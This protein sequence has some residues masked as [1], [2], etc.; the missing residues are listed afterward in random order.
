VNEI[1]IYQRHNLQKRNPF[2]LAIFDDSSNDG[3]LVK[4][5]LENGADFMKGLSVEQ[6]FDLIF[7]IP[8]GHILYEILNHILKTN[9]DAN[10]VDEKGKTLLHHA[11]E[12]DHEML[13]QD[14][15]KG[16]DK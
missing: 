7:E 16:I 6:A 9:E 12:R 11:A 5:M 1:D 13:V 2:F 3:E 4:L 8:N 14:T 10:N 15:R